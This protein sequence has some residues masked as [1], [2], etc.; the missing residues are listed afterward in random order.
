MRIKS[1]LWQEMACRGMREDPAYPQAN[2]F[3]CTFAEKF[4]DAVIEA[5]QAA[6]AEA[7]LSAQIGLEGSRV[8]A[9]GGGR[10]SSK[11]L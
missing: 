5:R 11:P 9:G 2:T 3:W 7:D 10:A 1:T 4:P 6:A 8:A